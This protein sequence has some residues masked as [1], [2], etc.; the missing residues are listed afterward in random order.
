MQSLASLLDQKLLKI[1]LGDVFILPLNNMYVIWPQV[2][3]AQKIT[4]H[5]IL[6]RFLIQIPF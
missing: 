3:Y 6:S 4:S 2:S 1:K 5:S